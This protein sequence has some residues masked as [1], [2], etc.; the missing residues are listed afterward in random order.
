[1]NYAVSSQWQGGFGASV[2][3]TNLGDPLS[4]WT[5]TWSYGAGQTVTQAWNTSLTQSG[6]AVTAKNVS[7]NGCDPDQRLGVV[8]LQRLVDE[9]QPGADELRPE[10]CGV[11]RCRT[12]SRPPSPQPTVIP[13]PTSPPP[14]V[15]A[16]VTSAAVVAAADV[17]SAVDVPLDVDRLAGATRRTGWVSLKDFTNVVYNGKHLVYASNV[18]NGVVRLDELQPR[19]PTGPTWP[20]PAR[21][22]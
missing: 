15:P 18:D 12:S 16:A 11:H 3:I 5:L 19:S 6:A 13:P 7:Y 2:A 22:G 1:M 14:V 17:R 10:R 4:S 21:T 9:Q 8:R 20:R